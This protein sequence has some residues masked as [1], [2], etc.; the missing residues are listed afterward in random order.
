MSVFRY[1]MPKFTY[2][3]EE[4]HLYVAWRGSKDALFEW[5]SLNRN[6][7]DVEFRQCAYWRMFLFKPFLKFDSYALFKI[8][9]ELTS[10]LIL[11][12]NVWIYRTIIY[13]WWNV[14]CDWS[15]C[16]IFRIGKDSHLCE[17]VDGW[18]NALKWKIKIVFNPNPISS[19]DLF[20][21]VG[22]E[23]CVTDC[24]YLYE[25]ISCHT[26][27]RYVV[28]PRYATCSGSHNVLIIS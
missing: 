8:R 4:I 2:I 19:R 25:C 13:D 12:K 10:L 28:F 22:I 21:Q 11:F 18:P 6:R 9:F 3:D 24:V 20:I 1:F 27:Y 16:R 5:M 14:P 7:N 17:S 15:T 26:R 23:C